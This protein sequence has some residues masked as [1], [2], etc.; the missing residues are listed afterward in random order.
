MQG[1]CP[2]CGNLFAVVEERL[3]AEAREFHLVQKDRQVA[4]E[5][6]VESIM[7]DE[8]WQQGPE[9]GT[10]GREPRDIGRPNNG[11]PIVQSVRRRRDNG[12]ADSDRVRF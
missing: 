6:F 1:G 10:V 3:K 2:R 11:S 5:V 12:N 7:R 4:D 9:R 8:D